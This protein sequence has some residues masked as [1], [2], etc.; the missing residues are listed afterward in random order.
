MLLK[1]ASA[2]DLLN[3]PID[4]AIDMFDSLLNFIKESGKIIYKPSLQNIIITPESIQQKGMTFDHNFGYS[5]P[6]FSSIL[7]KEGRRKG[8]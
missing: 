7:K 3:I 2:W 4:E 5:F 6:P 1:D 8:E